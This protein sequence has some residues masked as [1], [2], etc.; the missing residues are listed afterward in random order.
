MDFMKKPEVIK[1]HLDILYKSI[2][3]MRKDKIEVMLGEYKK[4]KAQKQREEE[5]RL[6]Y[7]NQLRK[8]RGRSTTKKDRP[9][10][11]FSIE[12]DSKAAAA[13]EDRTM[14]E[15]SHS[16]DEKAKKNIFNDKQ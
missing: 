15:A 2:P 12:F 9:K 16:P 11:E 14:T 6:Q 8:L 7:Q 5:E 13:K 4:Q 10:E 3:F 1:M